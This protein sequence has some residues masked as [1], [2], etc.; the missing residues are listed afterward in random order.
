MDNISK[1]CLL[2]I[3][4]L[5]LPTQKE[6][7]G[8]HELFLSSCPTVTTCTFTE[9]TCS[10]SMYHTQLKMSSKIY[11]SFSPVTLV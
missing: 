6:E 7:F 4:L 10:L 1:T 11:T 3:Y 8:V 5:Y 9:G 2:P